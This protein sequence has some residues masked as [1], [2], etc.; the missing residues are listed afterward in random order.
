MIMVSR[1]DTNRNTWFIA[2]GGVLVLALLIVFVA[3][4]G[5]EQ[6]SVDGVAGD[7]WP[8]EVTVAFQTIPNGEAIVRHEGWLEEA[9]TEELGVAVKWVNFASGSD[10][11]AAL[12]SGDVD[13]GLVGST[14]FATGV[15][16][17]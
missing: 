10:V 3:S 15:E 4:N 7:Q 14:L 16:R 5:Y 1:R 11:N 17:G 9:L 12:A 2:A 8:D 6:P 13:L